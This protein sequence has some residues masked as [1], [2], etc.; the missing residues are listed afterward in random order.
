M[1]AIL[2]VAEHFPQQ[3]FSQ[4]F[5]NHPGEHT[6]SH[7]RREDHPVGFVIVPAAHGTHHHTVQCARYML[8]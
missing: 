5:R 2:V 1:F 3:H 8:K 6:E 4:A 7:V